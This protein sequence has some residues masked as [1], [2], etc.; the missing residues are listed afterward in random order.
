[1]AV[2]AVIAGAQA[3]AV[4]TVAVTTSYLGSD[5][6][7]TVKGFK[8][9]IGAD[10]AARSLT[11]KVS[12]DGGTTFSGDIALNAGVPYTV[13]PRRGVTAVVDVKADASCNVAVI[14]W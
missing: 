9:D 10:A 7:I 13:E 3:E 14:A 11:V 6:W 8:A 2:T 5:D 4:G 1:M 12:F